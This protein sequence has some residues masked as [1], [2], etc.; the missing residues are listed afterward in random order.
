MEVK[1]K[2]QGLVQYDCSHSECFENQEFN[3]IPRDD[4]VL[5]DTNDGIFAF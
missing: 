3:F 1:K 4:N 5:G 2:S